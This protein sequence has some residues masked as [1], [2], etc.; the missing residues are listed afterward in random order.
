MNNYF[1]RDYQKYQQQL[2][3]DW[4]TQ[5]MQ[6]TCHS[7][8]FIRCLGLKGIPTVSNCM[9]IY[10]SNYTLQYV[11]VLGEVRDRTEGETS[12]LEDIIKPEMKL[13]YLFIC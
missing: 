12:L 5:T 1:W 4:N 13:A 8:L 9:L 6:K 11:L 2:N 3:E 10:L 7:Y